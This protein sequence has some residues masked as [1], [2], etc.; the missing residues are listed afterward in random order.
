M[1]AVLLIVIPLLSGL[2]AFFFKDEKAVR[3]WALFASIATLVISVLGLSFLNKTQDLQFTG[4][5]MG[6]L[7]SSFSVKLD[8]LGQLLCLLTALAF[9]IVF[10]ATW[11]STYKNA[12]RFFA[13]MLLSQAGL[14]GVFLA[15]DALLLYFFWELALIPVYFLCSQWGGERRIQV[16]FKFFIYTFVGSL[17]MLIGII[18][19]YQ[20]TP[21][22]SFSLQSF[23]NIKP[24]GPTQL[25]VFW[26]FFIAFAV[27]MPIFPFHTWQPDTYE[28]SP[29]AVTMILSGVMVKMGLLGILRWLLPVLPIASYQWGDVVMSLSVIGIIY[30]SLLAMQQDDL[31]RLVAYSSIAHI[32]L[33][34]AAIFAVSGIGIHGVM[35]QLF[36]HGINIIGLWVVIELI[37]RQFGTRKISELGGLAQKAPAMATLFVVVAMANIALP[38][39]NG[40][41]GEFLMFNGIF[42]TAGSKY[43]L[44]FTIL[45]GL[46]II[47]GAVYMLNMIRKV[48]YGNTNALTERA[49]DIS[50]GERAVLVAIIAGIF[51]IGVYPKPVFDLTNN[52]VDAIINNSFPGLKGH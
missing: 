52:V 39:T 24:G 47:L 43:A 12:N 14:M 46:G 42:N 37:E 9:P 31:K 49:Y 30:G 18:Y 1:I 21:D 8:G 28:Q 26:L 50:Y 17:L 23:I 41:I 13:L 7:G 20:L 38:L 6:N 33:M 51:V 11:N 15:M 4:E 10:I 27:K 35:I 44:T 29:T 36:N 3:S 25:W 2:L 5:W 40:F 22:H 45:A 34:C 48:F 32:G 16:T 19:L